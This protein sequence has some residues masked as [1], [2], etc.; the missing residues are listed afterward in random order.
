MKAQQKRTKD[1]S[2]PGIRQDISLARG[3]GTRGNTKKWPL[4]MQHET[5]RLIPDASLRSNEDYASHPI[6]YLAL[7]NTNALTRAWNLEDG[8]ECSHS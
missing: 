6:R 1:E 3:N 5:L 7:R 2:K 8:R 4:G